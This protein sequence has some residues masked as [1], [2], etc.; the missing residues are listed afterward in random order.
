MALE[1]IIIY[2][3]K[4]SLIQDLILKDH[5]HCMFLLDIVLITMV[6]IVTIFSFG[7][8]VRTLLLYIT[9]EPLNTIKY[10]FKG[11]FHAVA[12]FF[13]LSSF[14]LTFRLLDELHNSDNK[15]RSLLVILMKYFIRRVFRIYIPFVI[16]CSLIKFV[17]LRFIGMYSKAASTWINMVI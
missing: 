12:G 1:V 3:Y 16:I 13:I 8:L 10:F 6:F 9:I 11:K 17:S 15:L 7:H 14:L 4:F 5:W 2:F